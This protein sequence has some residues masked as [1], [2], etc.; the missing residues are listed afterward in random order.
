M[1]PETKTEMKSFLGLTGYYQKFVP[2]YAT[3]PR[4]LSNL[5][6]KGKREKVEW[7]P[8][9]EQM[10]Q[11]LKK[12]LGE[13]MVLIIPGFSRPINVVVQTDHDTSN[14]G[15]GAVP[16]RELMIRSTQWHLQATY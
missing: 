4:H 9:C 3:I 16:K 6:K 2:Q 11:T 10:F 1:H 5:L 8:E 13:L 14:V 15:I 12:K 7:T